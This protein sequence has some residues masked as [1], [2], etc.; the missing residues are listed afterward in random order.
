[1][2]PIENLRNKI[3]QATEARDNAVITTAIVSVINRISQRTSDLEE[4]IL[5][6]GK[7]LKNIYSKISGIEKRVSIIEKHKPKDG[8]TPIKGKDYIDGKDGYT[9]IKGKDY[10]DGKDGYTPVKG[11]DYFDGING[12]DGKTPIKGVDYWTDGDI[13]TIKKSVTPLKGRDYTDGSPD[14]GEDIRTKL[15]ALEGD[16]RLDA[17]AIKNLPQGGVQRIGS[18]GFRKFKELED[19]PSTYSGQAGKIVRV[20]SNEKGL[21]FVEGGSSGVETDPV[22]TSEKDTLAL[23]TELPTRTS[24]LENDSGF[25]TTGDIPTSLS[26]LSG[27]LDDIAD[28]STYVKSHNDYTDTEQSKLS[29]IAEGAEV[30]V[31]ADWNATSGDAQILNKPNLATV[32]TSGSYNDLG[33]LPDIGDASSLQGFGI[34]ETDPTDGKILVYRS[35]SNAYVLEDKPV[36]AGTP[37]ASDVVFTPAG[38]VSSINVQDAI[39]EVDSKKASN[40]FAIA[41]AIALG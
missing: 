20:K 31:N 23:K 8:Y 11:K 12:K 14:T 5:T 28:G 22:Y 40:N 30:N 19:T 39:E 27:T 32:A 3:K 36:D 24:E 38:N 33:N 9:P 10:R 6:V 25:I 29:S 18:G 13:Q 17:K 34:T 21:E 15:E 2:D 1:M 41:M 26:D 16:K 4:A 37:D 35:A 7:K